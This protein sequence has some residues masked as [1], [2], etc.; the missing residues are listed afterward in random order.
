MP[1][2]LKKKQKVQN[3]FNDMTFHAQAMDSIDGT[4]DYML[5]IPETQ[6]HNGIWKLMSLH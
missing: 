2:L 4:W 3:L 6:S 5:G 1:I